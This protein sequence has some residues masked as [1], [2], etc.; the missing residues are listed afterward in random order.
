MSLHKAGRGEDQGPQQLLEPT[1]GMRHASIRRGSAGC[2]L[3]LGL[4]LSVPLLAPARASCGRGVALKRGGLLVA[5]FEL[6]AA[7]Q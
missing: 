6:T 1:L 7:E 2:L 4:S 3:P 5:Y